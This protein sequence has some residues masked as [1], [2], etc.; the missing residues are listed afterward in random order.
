MEES[1]LDAVIA[2]GEKEFADG[3]TIVAR[4]SKEALKQYHARRDT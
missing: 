1:S 3:R 2:Q 4:S